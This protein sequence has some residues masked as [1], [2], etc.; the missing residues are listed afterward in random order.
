MNA[1]LHSNQTMKITKSYLT[2]DHY[3]ELTQSN[4]R[5]EECSQLQMKSSKYDKVDGRAMQK[6]SAIERSTLVHIIDVVAIR[7]VGKDKVQHTY[8]Y[9]S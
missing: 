1:K 9:K 3:P 5:K 2:H 8:K 4:D 7:V 6:L